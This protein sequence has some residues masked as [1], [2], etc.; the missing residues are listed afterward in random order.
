MKWGA[1]K[2]LS[3]FAISNFGVAIATRQLWPLFKISFFLLFLAVSLL[4][5]L[6]VFRRASFVAQEK[7]TIDD[8]QIYAI[9]PADNVI[10]VGDKNKEAEKFMENQ[11]GT[12]TQ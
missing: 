8:S 3:C 4:S 10:A 2:A 6:D 9:Q 7:R 11:V 1:S 5:R 12:E